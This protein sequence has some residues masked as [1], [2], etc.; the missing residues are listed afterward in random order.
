MI[1]A[2]LLPGQRE[3][4]R[5]VPIRDHLYAENRWLI[6]VQQAVA[7][8][9]EP[10]EQVVLM[11]HPHDHATSY[12]DAFPQWDHEGHPPGQE[13]HAKEIRRAYFLGE[14][15]EVWGA[16][17]PQAVKAYLMQDQQSERY[18]WLAEEA[19][20]V[21]HYRQLWAAAP[22]PP[23][24]VTTDAVVVQSGHV[25]LVRR[26]VRPGL[27]QYALPGGY[28]AAKEQLVEGMVRRLREET[29]LK[30]PKPVLEGSIRGS[31]VFDA[32]ERSAR[33]RVLTHAYRIQLKPGPLPAVRGGEQ[34]EKAFWLPLGELRER[35][36][37]LFEDHLHIIEC[38]LARG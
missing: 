30:V 15:A 4:V 19:A 17:L 20:F 31:A 38:L 29:G 35:E 1:I 8:A 36:E 16:E 23:T 28:L 37:L 21:E 34:V 7:Q 14:P 9:T 22:Y 27:G 18:R 2:A 33:G 24:F 13:H 10:G 11:G 25:L 26:R 32:P 6:E 3:R 12:L 5:C